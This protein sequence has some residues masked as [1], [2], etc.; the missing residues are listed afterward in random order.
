M[1]KTNLILMSIFAS[2]CAMVDP[3]V[4]SDEAKMAGVI[5]E[6]NM[7]KDVDSWIKNAGSAAVVFIN[8]EDNRYTDDQLPEYM[9]HDA[10]YSKIK[11]GN[12]SIRILER[13]PDILGMVQRENDGVDL[14]ATWL[15]DATTAQDSLTIEQRRNEVG[16]LIRAVVHDIAPQDN[17]VELDYCCEKGNN[18]EYLETVIANEV[19]SNKSELLQ[20]L[21]KEYLGLYPEVKSQKLQKRHVDVDNADYL[22]AY[23]VYDFGTYKSRTIDGGANRI[24]YVKLHMRVIDMD[25]GEVLISD[26]MENKDTDRL[27][28]KEVSALMR[29]NASQ[30]DYGRPSTRSSN[31]GGDSSPANSAP[32]S[33]GTPDGGSSSGGM[34]EKAKTAVSSI[35]NK[36]MFWK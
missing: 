5:K 31:S 25:S 14:P 36:L 21:V 3:F 6:A 7:A 17:L 29:T 33:Y 24:S 4:K 35:V 15:P 9:L 18:K 22:I 32:K 23:R 27:S 13:D 26:F 16:A 20:K 11:D 19:G 30:S 1:N 12:S 8:M 2:G 10:I 34:V 28:R